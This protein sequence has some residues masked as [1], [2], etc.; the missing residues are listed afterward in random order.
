MRSLILL[1]SCFPRQLGLNRLV[2]LDYLV[3][4][5]EDIGGPPSLHPAEDSRAAEILVR[6]KLVDAGLALMGTKALVHRHATNVGFRYGAGES[7]GGFVD[8]LSSPYALG[9]RERA[10]WLNEHVAEVT[11]A[12]LVS[13]LQ[14]R[15]GRWG[16]E[17]MSD[18]EG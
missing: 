6:R 2:I 1:T 18:V 15:L 5:T 13:Q 10:A 12:G 9:L 7:A 11:D 4:H 8:L 3:V 14:N 16:P 17:F